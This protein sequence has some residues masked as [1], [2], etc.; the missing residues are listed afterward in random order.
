LF[1]QYLAGFLQFL[2]LTDIVQRSLTGYKDGAH[3]IK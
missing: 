3:I 1:L 2:F